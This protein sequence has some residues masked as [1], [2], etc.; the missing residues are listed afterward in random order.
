MTP[1]IRI[2]GIDPGPDVTGY[3]VVERATGTLGRLVEGGIIRTKHKQPLW[4]KLDA[5]H[6]GVV[7][8]IDKYHPNTLAIE[9][10][11]YAKNVRT[12][13]VLGHAR[14]VVLLAAARAGLDVAEFPPATVK[15]T[16]VGNGGAAKKQVAYMVRQ[17]LNL[18]SPP[19]PSDAADGVAV[20]LT[21]LLTSKA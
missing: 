4:H 8:L 6:D 10:I 18:K 16:I 7:Q 13:I 3:G 9:S 12:T 17:L 11:F 14:G 2:P 21:F 19:E 5:I 20:A 15:K 1:P